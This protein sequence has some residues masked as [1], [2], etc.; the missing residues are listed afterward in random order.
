MPESLHIPLELA[1]LLHATLG[2]LADVLESE[3]H[4][5][6]PLIRRVLSAYVDGRDQKLAGQ[7][8]VGVL[9][10]A[11]VCTLQVAEAVMAMVNE[12]TLEE[13][14]FD[15]WTNEVQ[16]VSEADGKTA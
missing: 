2:P 11:K 16:G 6:V 12:L 14:D 4:V 1:E 7:Y 10:E 9:G 15:L 3:G 13:V 5:W 8:G